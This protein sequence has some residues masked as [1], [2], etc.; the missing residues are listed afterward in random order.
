MYSYFTLVLHEINFT[1]PFCTGGIV[2]HSI[3]I[4]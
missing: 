3:S 1:I 4:L 2:M